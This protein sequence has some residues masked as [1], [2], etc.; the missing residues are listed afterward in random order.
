MSSKIEFNMYR[1]TNYSVDVIF[2]R[3]Q[4]YC[5]SLIK[6]HIVLYFKRKNAKF[7]TMQTGTSKINYYLSINLLI[8]HHAK[9]LNLYMPLWL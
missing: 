6:Y 9:Q 7:K 5:T 3:V 4:Y 1:K 8:E 2:V